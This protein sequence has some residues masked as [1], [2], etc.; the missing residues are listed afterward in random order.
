MRDDR[1]LST[2][3]HSV[4]VGSVGVVVDLYDL[5]GWVVCWLIMSGS[6]PRA[7]GCKTAVTAGICD[8]HEGVFHLTAEANTKPGVRHRAGHVEEH[9]SIGDCVERKDVDL[10]ASIF[11]GE[12]SRF[13]VVVDAEVALDSSR[14]EEGQDC[15]RDEAHVACSSAGSQSQRTCA[16]AICDSEHTVKERDEDVREVAQLISR[17]TRALHLAGFP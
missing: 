2:L 14:P 17:A 15:R 8:D 13:G 1:A 4:G 5:S 16:E 7:D 6:N 9:I 12:V 3:G 10:F 11:K